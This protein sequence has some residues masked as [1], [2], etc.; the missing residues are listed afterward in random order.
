M[1][2]S[3]PMMLGL[4]S[5]YTHALEYYEDHFLNVISSPS[6]D[7]DTLPKISI[8]S[9]HTCAKCNQR[10]EYAVHDISKGKFICKGCRMWDEQFS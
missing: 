3:V 9:D 4:D 2:P 1:P 7:A 5:G 10:N 6:G 8:T